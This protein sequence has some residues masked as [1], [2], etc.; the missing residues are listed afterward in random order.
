[1]SQRKENENSF[2]KRIYK[3]SFFWYA[4]LKAGQVYFNFFERTRLNRPRKLGIT[5]EVTLTGYRGV[6]GG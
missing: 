1:M 2:Q 4:Y 6:Q 3:F 5:P